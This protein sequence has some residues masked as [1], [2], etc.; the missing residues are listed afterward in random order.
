MTPKDI[1]KQYENE[2]QRS[3]VSSQP[4]VYR[5]DG[6]QLKEHQLDAILSQVGHA[7][8][9]VLM[10]KVKILIIVRMSKRRKKNVSEMNLWDIPFSIRMQKNMKRKI[11]IFNLAFPLMKISSKIYK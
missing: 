11:F 7:S 3:E 1:I 9:E 4:E 10:K 8:Q 2:A 6:T 5:N